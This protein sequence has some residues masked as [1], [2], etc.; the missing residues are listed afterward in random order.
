M[1]IHEAR[2]VVNGGGEEI[3]SEILDAKK[4][5]MN[6]NIGNPGQ[7]PIWVVVTVASLQEAREVFKDYMNTHRGLFAPG[8]EQMV[9]NLMAYDIER[10]KTDRNT[11]FRYAHENVFVSGKGW[12]SQ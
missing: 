8:Y 3:L 6:V 12:T 10:G 2:P 7:D 5:T 9:I 4:I 11:L 1:P